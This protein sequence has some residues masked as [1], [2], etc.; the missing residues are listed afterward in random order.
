LNA[1]ARPYLDRERF[2]KEITDNIKFQLSSLD[3]QYESTVKPSG[4]QT[5]PVISTSIFT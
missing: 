3:S 4:G 1:I 5:Q 2:D